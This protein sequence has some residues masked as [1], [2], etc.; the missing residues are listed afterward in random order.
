ME[1]RSE[2]RILSGALQNPYGGAPDR[3]YLE[4]VRRA[5]D[6]LAGPREHTDPDTARAC[7]SALTE[8]DRALERAGAPRPA[9]DPAAQREVAWRRGGG[10][11]DRLALDLLGDDHLTAGELTGRLRGALPGRYLDASHVRPVLARLVA[12]GE[13]VRDA[14]PWHG[15][16]RYRYSRPRPLAGPIADLDRAARDEVSRALAPGTKD[17]DLN[18]HKCAEHVAALLLAGLAPRRSGR[19]AGATWTSPTAA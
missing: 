7:R 18:G 17:D 3:V 14:E 1:P 6:A 4:L 13:L 2:V 16:V 9:A 19:C 15:R 12:A 11:R 10:G 5:R 8:L